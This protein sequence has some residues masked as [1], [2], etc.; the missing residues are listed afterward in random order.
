MRIFGRLDD[1]SSVES[2]T[3]TQSLIADLV[4]NGTV[5]AVSGLLTVFAVLRER[6]MREHL[7]GF[8]LQLRFITRP[9]PGTNRALMLNVC[10]GSW[11][12]NSFAANA[13]L[14]VWVARG[15]RHD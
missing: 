8:A 4:T 11:V 14:P 3:R 5:D 12:V 9:R 10:G 2:F 15:V 13:C 7:A 1:K 6:K